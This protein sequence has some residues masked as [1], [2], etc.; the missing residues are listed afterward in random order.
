MVAF[1]QKLGCESVLVMAKLGHDLRPLLADTLEAPLP[2]SLQRL[3][4]DFMGYADYQEVGGPGRVDGSQ[5][6]GG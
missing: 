6:A 1:Q 5:V 2:A 3:A 4:D